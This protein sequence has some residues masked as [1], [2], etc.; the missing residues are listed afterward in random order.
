M[1]SFCA[2]QTNLAIHI[3]NTGY[4]HLL[5]PVITEGVRGAMARFDMTNGSSRSLQ[6]VLLATIMTVLAFSPL[7]SA[8][9]STTITNALT[10]TW[11]DHP[12]Y[13]RCSFLYDSFRYVELKAKLL[14]VDDSR[15]LNADDYP[16]GLKQIEC[17]IVRYATSSGVYG[18]SIMKAVVWS[19]T[20]PSQTLF[21]FNNA[22]LYYAVSPNLGTLISTAL[23]RE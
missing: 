7:V 9:N 8:E 3:G 21:R 20:G 16:A 15:V 4:I 6:S 19:N 23:D 17:S 14:N 18:K 5:V 2:C 22:L 13:V 11:K 1:L 10:G 12:T